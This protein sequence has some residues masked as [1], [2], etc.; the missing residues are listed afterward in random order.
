MLLEAGATVDCFDT[1]DYTPLDYA[2][3]WGHADSVRALL[4]AGSTP[5]LSSSRFYYRLLRDVRNLF[6]YACARSDW[7]PSKETHEEMSRDV[8]TCLIHAIAARREE[9][10]NLALEKLSRQDAV[11]LGLLWTQHL[12]HDAKAVIYA[13]QDE[14]FDVPPGLWTA[15]E[16]SLSSTFAGPGRLIDCMPI[17]FETVMDMILADIR[18]YISY[19]T[20][21]SLMRTT[22]T[23]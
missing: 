17:A 19:A 3:E 6:G 22:W 18:H 1:A 10:R 11:E 15:G 16:R 21:R 12:D 5:F 9:L 13:L 4:R 2:C 14:G 20:I 7:A 8:V 23:C